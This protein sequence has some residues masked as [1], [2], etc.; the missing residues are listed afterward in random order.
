MKAR[1]HSV[2][3]TCDNEWRCCQRTRV[4]GATHTIIHDKI[5]AKGWTVDGNVILCS[6]CTCDLADEQER[7]REG[8]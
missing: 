5:I 4:Y 2:F 7:L 3:F 1:Q 8:W 6:E